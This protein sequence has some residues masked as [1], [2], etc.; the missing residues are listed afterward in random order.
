MLNFSQ[1]SVLKGLWSSSVALTSSVT[2]CMGTQWLP[3]QKAT[4]QEHGHETRNFPVD[5]DTGN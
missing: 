2:H 3:R 1:A 4:M 5:Q